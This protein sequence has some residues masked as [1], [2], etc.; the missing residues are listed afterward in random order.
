MEIAMTEDKN[1][2]LA[3]LKQ[4]R[5]VLASQDKL[6][7]NWA[8][9][10]ENGEG[11]QVREPLEIDGD[12][13]LLD[14]NGVDIR[15]IEPKHCKACIIGGIDLAFPKSRRYNLEERSEAQE[16]LIQAEHELYARGIGVP[17]DIG[18]VHAIY[19]TAI[20]YVEGLR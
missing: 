9:V 18:E 12:F 4:G 7:R 11:N 5:V 13:A 19:D 1:K 14:E 20:A 3:L 16:V 8:N 10:L 17:H 15:T 6:V 2:V